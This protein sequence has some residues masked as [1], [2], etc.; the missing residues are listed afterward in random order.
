[1][2][3]VIAPV[4]VQATGATV[5]VGDARE[6]LA[7]LPDHSV[8]CCVT[9]PPYW[10]LR[11]YDL[12]PDCRHGWGCRGRDR[13]GAPPPKRSSRLTVVAVRGWTAG[14]GSPFCL[15]CGAWLGS[16][17]LEPTPELHVEHL[18]DVFRHLRRVL[19]PTGTLWLNLGD[20]YFTR[21]V[22]RDRGNRDVIKGFEGQVLPDWRDYARRGR[23]RYSS[24]HGPS[25]TRT[26]LA[27][28]GESRSRC[29]RTAGTCDP[30]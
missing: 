6:V 4:R 14:D 29:R 10:G 13:H 12:P 11:D 3:T 27:S 22:L 24:R 16:L 21:S 23:V 9:S 2:V 25:K 1:M 18:L 28:P 20:S 15:L 8:D 30:T 19:K 17:G 26:W 7:A 5:Y